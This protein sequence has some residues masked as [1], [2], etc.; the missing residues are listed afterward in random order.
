MVV[1][2]IT[3]LLDIVDHQQTG[4]LANPFDTQ[5]LANTINWIL[6]H[7]NPEQLAQAARDKVL[8][9]FDRQVVA[10]KYI[11]LYESVVKGNA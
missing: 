10:E 1:F 11:E 9:A 4:Y 8:R 3:G 5:D 7:E 2:G 6:Q